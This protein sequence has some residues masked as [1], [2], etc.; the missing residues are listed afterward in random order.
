MA[1][2]PQ[3]PILFST[4]NCYGLN[5]KEPHE[6]GL[7]QRSLRAY[8]HAWSEQIV[9]RLHQCAANSRRFV[10]TD[11]VAGKRLRS[12]PRH[13]SAREGNGFINSQQ[14]LKYEQALVG[15]GIRPIVWRV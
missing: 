11:P 3:T 10:G 8:R 7:G 5:D 12:F 9:V 2:S 4:L 6:G 1:L 14:V 13:L 15:C